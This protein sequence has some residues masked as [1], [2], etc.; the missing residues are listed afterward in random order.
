M[1]SRLLFKSVAVQWLIK[2]IAHNLLTKDGELLGRII[3]IINHASLLTCEDH[4][5]VT[6]FLL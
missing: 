1:L 3:A 4:G 2:T 6:S 5:L